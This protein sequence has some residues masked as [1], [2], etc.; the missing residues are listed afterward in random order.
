[1]DNS[2]AIY[3]TKNIVI[4]DLLLFLRRLSNYIKGFHIRLADE[5]TKYKNQ[6]PTPR[7][8]FPVHFLSYSSTSQ[9]C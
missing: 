5:D 1:M 9:P 6:I 4:V 3:I 2:T 8:A 7:I